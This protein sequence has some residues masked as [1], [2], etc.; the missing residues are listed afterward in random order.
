MGSVQCLDAVDGCYSALYRLKIK[1]STGLMGDQLIF[2]HQPNSA[3]IE[4]REQFLRGLELAPPTV[5]VETNFLYGEPR[6]FRK[7][8]AW[9]QF[10]DFLRQNYAIVAERTFPTSPADSDAP[11]Y[12]IYFR[13]Y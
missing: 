12:R 8:E 1:Q 10:D 5:F 9:P 11:G 6:S 3:I 2:S 4:F 7:I 13:V